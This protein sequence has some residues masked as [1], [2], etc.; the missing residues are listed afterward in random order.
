ME[1]YAD[2]LTKQI[3]PNTVQDLL[4]ALVTFLVAYIV[5][6]I[7]WKFLLNRVQTIAKKTKFK[8]DDVIV[9]VLE[10]VGGLFYIAV[11]L[12]IAVQSLSLS[13]VIT[14]IVKGIFLIAV[15]YEVI[16][17]T[18]RVIN[19]FVL[20]GMH[21]RSGGATTEEKQKVS[22]IFSIF[23]KITLW[24]FGLL[25]ILSNLGF[26]ITSLVAGLGI[27]GLAIS[28]ALQSV[29]TD[30]F[31]SLS[32]AIDKPFREG[33][34]IVVGTDKGT[35]KHIGIKTTRLQSLQGEEIVI[36]NTE[37]TTARV[38]NFRKLE[39]RRIVFKIGVKYSTSTDK[40][41][42]IPEIVEKCIESAGKTELDRVHFMEFGD[43][44]LNYE[45]VYFIGSK[46]YV[47]YMDAQQKMNL[48]ILEEFEKEGIEMAFPTQTVYIEK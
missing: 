31:S 19:F 40:L 7:I 47:D 24:S 30:V 32:I 43:F 48:A 44:S 12:F 1:N 33:D 5:L 17:L 3:G 16:K 28:L 37:L 4:I 34:F 25:L 41:K 21:A 22:G 9:D 42:K 13:P 39:K 38:Q 6:T 20:R 35:V 15:T 2:I 36:S 46:E 26:N 10:G 27:G 23:I 29:L 18:E 11:A 14:V 45:I 8:L